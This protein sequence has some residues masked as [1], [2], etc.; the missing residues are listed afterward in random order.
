MK[1]FSNVFGLLLLATVALTSCLGEG[2]SEVTVYND[3]AITEFTLGTLNRYKDGT[4]TTLTGANYGMGIEQV[5]PYRISN[6]DSL[7]MGTDVSHVVCTIK[8]K[9][10]GGLA[11]RGLDGNDV[12][13]NSTDSIDFSQER[14]L[15]VFSTDGSYYRDYQVK[16]LVAKTNSDTFSWQQY[17]A[18]DT[19]KI[20]T[21][22]SLRVVS[23]G[24]R[25]L[26]FGR[27]VADIAKSTKVFASTNGKTW[28]QV[29]TGVSFDSLAWKNV[30]V[31]DSTA[32]VLNGGVLQRSADGNSWTPVSTTSDSP[33]RQLVSASV[34]ELYAYTADGRMRALTDGNSNWTVEQLDD[35]LYNLPVSHIASTCLGYAPI[36]SACYVLLI[37]NNGKKSEVWHK[38][39]QYGGKHKGGKWVRMVSDGNR[40]ALPVQQHQSLVCHNGNILAVGASR[41]F[42]NTT[43]QGLTWRTSTVYPMPSGLTGYNFSVTADANGNMWMV[44]NYGEVWQGRFR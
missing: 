4:K 38:I 34:N 19:T 1:R 35:S 25:L 29:A 15:R 21:M 11:I 7:P 14:T 17:V 5:A 9:N 2:E 24:A 16:L 40:F 23:V 42:Y 32:F 13:Y 44:S 8:T 18:S 6:R 26:L 20:P 33:L 43:D 41:A 10:S 31:K 30:V 39:Q 36:D 37:G 27:E 3:A 28:N 12:W 22:D